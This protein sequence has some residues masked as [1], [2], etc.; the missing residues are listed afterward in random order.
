MNTFVFDT[1]STGLTS[2]DE[3]IQFSGLLL[4]DNLNLIRVVNFYCDTQVKIHPEASKV[5]GL[6]SDLVHKL[7]GGKFFEDYYCNEPIFKLKDMC[8]VGYNID[9]DTRMVNNTLRNNGLPVHNFG[10]R[11]TS[12]D[13]KEGIYC[14]DVMQVFAA[15]RHSHKVK[16]SVAAQELKFT[17]DSLDKMYQ[18]L[19]HLAGEYV[20]L[21]F[22]N[23]IYDA[24]ITWLLLIQEV[25]SN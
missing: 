25:R 8:W 17:Q 23:A 2:N 10:K 19:L 16:L 1:E 6:T 5:N 7:S 15:K 3:V 18:K 13:K 20:D 4:D 24:M 22:H 11:T 14:Y 21:T 9:F 12:L